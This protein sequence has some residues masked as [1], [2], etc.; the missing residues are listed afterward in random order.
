M[1]S[2][3]AGT[4]SVSRIQPHRTGFAE[5]L[6]GNAGVAAL[7][8]IRCEMG[9]NSGGIS[10]TVALDL[11]TIPVGICGAKTGEACVAP[12]LKVAFASTLVPDAEDAVAHAIVKIPPAL[13][14][15]AS[16]TMGHVRGR[17]NRP[18]TDTS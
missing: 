17:M 13:T 2:S 1:R 10:T 14:T 12:A 5:P 16:T 8:S 18:L 9:R 15:S 4:S 11:P 7:I 3:V 6:Y